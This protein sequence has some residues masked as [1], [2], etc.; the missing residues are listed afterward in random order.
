MGKG[1]D[2][3]AMTRLKTEDLIPIKNH[4]KNYSHELTEKT[5]HSLRG[6]ACHALGIDPKEISIFEDSVKVG[7]VPIMS[8]QGIIPGFSDAI[9]YIVQEIGFDAFVTQGFDVSGIGEAVVRKSDIIFMGDDHR[10]IA[11]NIK[12]GTIVDNSEATAKGYVAGLDLMCGGLNGQKVLII[13]CGPV[14]CNAAV[15]VIKRGGN[16]GIIDKYPQ[17]SLFLA[18]HIERL[19]GRKITIEKN[20]KQALRNY[21]CIIDATNAGNII[22]ADIITKETYIAA[23]GIPLGLTPTAVEKISDRLLHDPLEL[24]VTVMMIG[25]LQSMIIKE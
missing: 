6:I 8:G 11:L 25:A 5:G 18:D 10:F 4:L 24:G 2:Q 15:A 22:D 21:H 1:E 16:V 14:G 20:L 9:M 13:G 19:I 17:Y 23:P 7:I 3:K 12:T